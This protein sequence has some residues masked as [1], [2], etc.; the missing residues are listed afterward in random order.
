MLWTLLNLVGLVTVAAAC[1]LAGGLLVASLPQVAHDDLG[2][3]ARWCLGLGFWSVTLFVL[4]VVGMLGLPAMT[5]VVVALASWAYWRR[6]SFPARPQTLDGV[7][8][9]RIPWLGLVVVSALL[10]PVVALALGPTVSWDASTYHLTL[11]RLYLEHGGFRP[12]ELNVYSH[13]PLGVELLFAFALAVR[14]VVTAKLVHL[15]FGL[16]LSWL[17]VVACRSFLPAGRQLWAAGLAALVFLANGVVLF[18]LR[19]AYV[20]LAHAFYFTAALIFLLRWL[21]AADQEQGEP[22]GDRGLL[23]LA[24]L[25][26]GLAAGTKLNGIA[27][28][29]LLSLVALPTLR[30]HRRRWIRFAGYFVLPAV[31]LWLPWPV[32][33]AMG[34]GN[35]VYPLLHGLFGGPDWGPELAAQLASWQ[36]SIGMGRTALDYLLLP[37]RVL[38]EGGR[39]YERFDGM[40]SPLWFL[41]LPAALWRARGDVFVR[42]TLAAGGLYFVFWAATSQQMRLLI[43]ALP[44]F[45]LAAG[46]GNAALLE[47]LSRRD[48]RLL[49]SALLVVS[50]AAVAWRVPWRGG[51]AAA[52]RLATVSGDVVASAVPPIFAH[53]DEQLPADARLLFLATNQGYYCR[54]EYLADSFFEASQIAHWLAPAG[55]DPRA[56]R[57]L[58]A[59]RGI[60]H[61][62][63]DQRPLPIPFPPAVG[64]MLRSPDLARPL[65]Q[66]PDGRYV[67]FELTALELAVTSGNRSAG[68]SSHGPRDF[69]GSIRADP[70]VGGRG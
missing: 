2:A 45:A 62:L 58:L 20:D 5:A 66:S 68:S 31:A 55:D 47:R 61:I 11:P 41:L 64:V 48:R 43:P 12:V 37:W 33:S 4:A 52:I 28:V 36:R 44:A 13:W 7:E 42:R 29:V 19:V 25:A 59:E 8:P 15:G 18:E 24:G 9:Q 70:R 1:W 57:G 50:L 67:L 40:L 27:G 16:L 32:R 53:I 6:R 60:T 21:D 69:T 30:R 10:A 46:A 3:L 56:L 26:A 54:R 34:T 63:L 17:L 65:Y 49:G 14:G 38:V 22:T 35:P 39:G 51:A 23:L